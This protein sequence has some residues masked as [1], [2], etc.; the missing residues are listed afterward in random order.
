M[1][2]QLLQLGALAVVFLVAVKEF[3]SYLKNRTNGNPVK[4]ITDLR[5]NHLHEIK[6]ILKRI[7]E[8]QE[9][10]IEYLIWIKSRINGQ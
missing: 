7:D 8:K 3:F 2:N 9:R 10:Q 1:E 5:D 4:E 6:E